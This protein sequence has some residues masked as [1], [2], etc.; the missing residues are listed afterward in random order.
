[1]CNYKLKH[2]HG[3][4]KSRQ[5]IRQES[6]VKFNCDVCVLDQLTFANNSQMAAIV[7]TQLLWAGSASNSCLFN[8]LTG[9]YLF[10][11]MFL[12]S[13][14]RF[15]TPENKLRG[16][17]WCQL[18]LLHF[19]KIPDVS[20]STPGDCWC[21]ADSIWTHVLP[22]RSLNMHAVYFRKDVL[23]IELIFDNIDLL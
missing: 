15:V 4:K 21:L 2:W 17:A 12:Y 6:R 3:T 10:A 11:K 13:S 7:R 8:C 16:P 1:M 18:W 20:G 14:V 5:S 23:L 9:C 19:G 22:H